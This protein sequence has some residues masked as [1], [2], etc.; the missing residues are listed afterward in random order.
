MREYFGELATFLDGELTGD[1]VYTAGY[2]AEDSDFVRFNQ[3]GVR[4]AGSVSQ[5]SLSLDLIEG[6]RHATGSLTLAGQAAIDRE[7][8]RA[9]VRDLRAKREHV[10][11][12]P[13]LL[14]AT[15]PQS[16]VHAAEDRLPD[17][18]EVV[19]QVLSQGTGRDLVGVFASGGTHRGFA[20][21]LGQHNWDSRYSFNLDW[22]FYSQ[23]DKAAKASYAGFDWSAD[24]FQ[25]RAQGAAEQLSVLAQPA[26]TIPPGGYRVYLAPAALLEIVGMLSWGGFGLRAHR[27]KTTPLLR[28]IEEG[29]TLDASVTIAENIED[30]IAPGFQEA[31]F[32]R[33]PRVNL[34]VDGAYE[35]TLVSPR[36]SLEYGVP[37]NGASAAESPV[38]IELAAGRV[39]RSAV[40]AELGTGIFISNLWYLNY[41]DRSRCRTTG[42]TRFATFW[43]ENGVIQAPLNV[44]RFDETVFRMLGENL[45]GL[46]RERE[47]LL[48]SGTYGGRSTSSANLP[49]ALVDDFVLTL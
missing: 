25:E 12:D 4:Q 23:G 35:D 36:S 29:A 16:T 1:E 14:Y 41:S 30:G 46:T 31:G 2:R 28:M 7:R 17:S 37:T 19:E 18:H 15:D 27:T 20:N 5:R 43:V 33:P 13:L 39:P 26:R 32:L 34:I 22:S 38:S 8:L 40:L 48:D 24:D 21:S 6:R 9:L 42:M 45:S 47:L 10:P 11:D 3:S 49:G 44:M